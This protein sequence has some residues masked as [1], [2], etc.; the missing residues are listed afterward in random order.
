[1]LSQLTGTGGEKVIVSFNNNQDSKTTVDAMP[2]NDAPD[3]YSTLSEECLRKIMLSHNVTSP[4]LFGIAS[5]NGFSSNADELK[6][7][8]ALFSNMIIAPMQE[9]LLD[10]FEQILAYNNIQFKPIL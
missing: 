10:A 8:F 7:S 2:V 6:D 9:L 4:L 1:M 5:S 3:L